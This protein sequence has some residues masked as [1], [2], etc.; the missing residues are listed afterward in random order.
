LTG[1]EVTDAAGAQGAQ[2]RRAGPRQGWTSGPGLLAAAALLVACGGVALAQQ[3]PLIIGGAKFTLVEEVEE[4]EFDLL[5]E[6]DLS[7][8][9][10]QDE[11]VFVFDVS[12]AGR[13][14][15]HVSREK[16][17]FT[18]ATAQG[19]ES[20]GL[21]GAAP[22]LAEGPV[23]VCL[24]R[25]AWKMTA[26]VNGSVVARAWDDLPF[27][28]LVGYAGSSESVRLADVTY[29]PVGEIQFE[30]NF[31]RTADTTGE[32]EAVSG[33]WVNEET[34]EV[35]GDARQEG[36]VDFKSVNAF[37]FKAAGQ[38]PAIATAGYWFWDDYAYSVSV[39]SERGVMGLLFR[40]QDPQN[41]LLLRVATNKGRPVGEPSLQLLR[42]AGGQA[43]ELARA[44]P[45]ILSS[46]W[47][48]LRVEVV[49]DAI[50]AYLDDQFMAQAR[51]ATFASGGIGLYAEAT[52]GAFFDDVRV[53][54]WNVLYDN[55]ASDAP[56]RWD[57]VEGQWARRDG[58]RR[59]GGQLVKTSDGRGLALAGRLDWSG[60]IFESD[61]QAAPDGCAGL[62]FYGQGP[63]DY[64]ALRVGGPQSKQGYAGKA[65]LIKTVRGQATV[66]AEAPVALA[67]GRPA[68]L[69]VEADGPYLAGYVDGLRVVETVDQ[70]LTHGKVGLV[71]DGAPEVAFRNAYLRFIERRPPVIIP[72]TMVADEE[73]KRDWASP[74]ESWAPAEGGKTIHWNKGSLFG[75][76]AVE[77][78]IGGI[79]SVAG[80]LTVFVS[81]AEGEEAGAYAV[82]LVA[83]PGTTAL[84]VQITRDGQSLGAGSTSLDEGETACV[85]RVE[86]NGAYLMAFINDTCVA[87]CRM[88]QGTE[89]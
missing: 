31:M 16:V 85:F 64:F 10:P 33:Q 6:V 87:S 8:A 38:E 75:E 78:P 53:R 1:R 39:K 74:A 54:E 89:G 46:Q 82:S 56:G 84:Q 79:G 42:V 5:A 52:E 24:A 12:D 57:A 36:Q 45:P 9:R 60:Y 19:S 47:Y 62:A 18:R 81:E 66:L 4:P 48:R 11:A 7:S 49:E 35:R 43:H 21:Q 59:S 3:S 72:H 77:V 15:L 55:F 70:T 50:W 23:Q 28:G 68:H 14:A 2:T 69:Q 41:H 22:G 73:M 51:D 26:T 65:Q 27:G 17:F 67:A 37:S 29:Q 32:W 80:R 83:S 88:Q 40:Y 63:Q 13:H 25:R 61:A 58:S 20:I 44:N 76:S 34:I 71:A 30:D 86:L